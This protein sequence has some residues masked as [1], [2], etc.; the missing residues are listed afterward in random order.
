[1]NSF[2]SYKKKRFTKEFRAQLAK[3]NFDIQLTWKDLENSNGIQDNL[4]RQLLVT[5][6]ILVT[7]SYV[8]PSGG[9][10]RIDRQLV[11]IFSLVLQRSN[12][13]GKKRKDGQ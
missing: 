3:F 10:H 1:M 7:K 5:L 2:W 12:E 4:E 8:I 11:L 6:F 9:D 13:I